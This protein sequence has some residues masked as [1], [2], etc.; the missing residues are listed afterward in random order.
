LTGTRTHL[1]NQRLDAA[2]HP[3]ALAL[4]F[5]LFTGMT[6]APASLHHDGQAGRLTAHRSFK[7]RK[8]A[9]ETSDTSTVY[10]HDR[11]PADPVP[12]PNTPKNPS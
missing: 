3:E 9:T 1:G 10:H 6:H 4:R 11:S 12:P 5:A 7:P 2:G 8:E